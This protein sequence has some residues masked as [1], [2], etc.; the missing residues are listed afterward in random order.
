VAVGVADD[1]GLAEGVGSGVVDGVAVAVGS[2]LDGT[3]VAMGLV[4]VGGLAGVEGVAVG[5]ALGT[6]FGCIVDRQRGSLSPLSTAGEVTDST[7][8]PSRSTENVSEMNST[9]PVGMAAG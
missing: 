4:V 5:L 3:G 7:R 6:G 8:L 2:G 1:D 9:E